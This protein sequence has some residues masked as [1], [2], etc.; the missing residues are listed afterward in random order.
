MTQH[1]RIG[2][3]D[4]GIG[5]LTVARALREQL[6]KEGLLYVADNQRAPYGPQSAAA[7]LC[8][9]REITRFLIGQG[10]QLIVVACN[11]ATTVAID[12]LRQ[13]FP[14]TFFV[15]MEPAVKPAAL[16]TSSGKI[17]VMATELTLK[18][19][20]YQDLVDRYAP[21]VEIF[22]DPCKGLVPL[23]ENGN[24]SGASIRQKIDQILSPMLAAGIDTLVLGCT[25]YPLLLPVIKDRCGTFVKVIDPAPASATQVA[26]LLYRLPRQKS[27]DRLPLHRFYATGNSQSLETALGR[28]QWP[29]RLLIPQ[30]NLPVS[31][32]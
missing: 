25:H 10:A 16:H 32:H 31:D 13:D 7:I 27:S 4:S 28:L 3:F 14:D 30:L 12:V 29:H 15:G 2:I 26:R 8:Y 5:G 22:T 19:D 6:P 18:S 11:T 23:I 20:R 21:G 1:L 17:G 24:W 9:S